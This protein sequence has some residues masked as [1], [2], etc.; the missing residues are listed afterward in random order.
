MDGPFKKAENHSSLN[1]RAGGE[2]LN[3]ARLHRGENG[4][5]RSNE[6]KWR[7]CWRPMA[8]ETLARFKASLNQQQD[9]DCTRL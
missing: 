4:T 6:E 3:P 7:I 9:E 5:R 8:R 2:S 1:H